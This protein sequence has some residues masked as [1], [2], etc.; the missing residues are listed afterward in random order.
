MKEEVRLNLERQHTTAV[1][2]AER[3]STVE[4]PR[5]VPCCLKGPTVGLPPSGR[6][7]GDA[8]DYTLL[9]FCASHCP[10]HYVELVAAGSQSEKAPINAIATLE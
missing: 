3:T 10:R 8:P 1:H 2:V 4:A 9:G 5:A 6:L 7:L